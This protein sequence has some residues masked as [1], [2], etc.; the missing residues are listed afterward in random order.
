VKNKSSNEEV[1]NCLLKFNQ[2]PDWDPPALPPNHPIEEFISIV[3][4]NISNSNFP[5]NL[6]HDEN[7][8]VLERKALKSLRENKDI[9]LVPSDKGNSIVLLNT[10]DYIK[11]AERQLFDNSIY[12]KLDHDPTMKHN[13]IIQDFLQDNGP[14][15]GLSYKAIKLLTPK[16]P[17]TPVFYTLPKTHKPSKPPPGRPIVSSYG[18]PTERIS[19]YVDEILQPFVQSL[20]SYIKDTNDFLQKISTINQPL[21]Q[22]CLLVSVDVES[23]YTNI[24]HDDG[25]NASKTFLDSRPNDSKPSTKFIVQLM[26]FI[27]T[28]NHFKFKDQNFL[29]TKGTAMGTRMAP[30][31]ANLFMGLFEKNFLACQN[32]TPLI[33]FRY[34]DDIFIIWQHGIE[35]LKIF[36]QNLNQ[37]SNL[38]FTWNISDKLVTFLDADVFIE[39]NFLKTKIHIKDSNKMQYLHFSSCHPIHIKKSI[40]KSLSLRAKNLCSKQSDFN[41]YISKLSSALKDRGYPN[42]II[43]KQTKSSK[44][45]SNNYIPAN[46]PKFFTQYY[47][48]LNKINNI[49]R[50]S[51]PILQRSLETRNLF[52]KVP[53]VIFRKA[54]NLQNILSRPKLQ[55]GV[56]EGGNIAQGCNPCNKPRCGT[57]K[58]LLNS[59]NFTSS[60]TGRTYP[61]RGNIDCNTDNVIYQLTCKFCSKEYIGQTTNPLRIR[62]TNHRFDVNHQNQTRPVS[63]HAMFHKQTKLEKCFNLKGVYHRPNNLCQVPDNNKYLNNYEVAHQ[64]ILNSRQPDGPNIR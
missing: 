13:R 25:I 51:F 40:P 16:L 9:V 12:S 20:P 62:M 56:Y 10:L 57:C 41:N 24:L 2:N 23:L 50:V 32:L 29:Q 47:P 43:D 42:K 1:P 61:I 36:L 55:Q 48:G 58:M 53:K 35:S 17:R 33:W 22:N 11:E 64:L 15:E 59:N 54:P 37:F 8:S 5:D 27:L 6:K 46:D 52:S 3:L 21:P 18:C 14:E 31:Y 60:S 30:S 44:N 49:L 39:S 28:L 4:S 34:I 7:V 45:Q 63:S 26:T 19:A 38:N